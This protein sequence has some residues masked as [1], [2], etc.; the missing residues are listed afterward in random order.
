MERNIEGERVWT[1]FS[2]IANLVEVG[3]VGMCL[4]V[5]KQTESF[6]ILALSLESDLFSERCI[7]RVFP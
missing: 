6:T 7:L 3:A 4:Q 5:H 1:A 2:L